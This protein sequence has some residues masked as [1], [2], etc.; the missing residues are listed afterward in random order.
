MYVCLPTGRYPLLQAC[1]MFVADLLFSWRCVCPCV[2]AYLQDAIPSHPPAFEVFGADVLIDTRGCV[3]VLEINSSPSLALDTPLD[4][5]V[6]TCVCVSVHI[7]PLRAC[8]CNTAV[9]MAPAWC[10]RHAT[11]VCVP[12]L[13]LC[14][15]VRIHRVIKPRMLRDAIAIV[16]PLPFDRQTLLEVHY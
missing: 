9:F 14:V 15:C 12:S 16:D 6:C 7:T 4:R 3:W 8:T 11:T 10:S 2:C 5:Y 13:Y 1:E